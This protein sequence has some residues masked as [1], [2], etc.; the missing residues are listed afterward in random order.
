MSE[1]QMVTT[2][3]KALTEPQYK[4]PRPILTRLGIGIG[5]AIIDAHIKINY[6][7]WQVRNAEDAPAG[8][9]IGFAGTFA[10]ALLTVGTIAIA[11]IFT[12]ATFASMILSAPAIIVGLLPAE[13]ILS[14]LILNL[15]LAI[16][17][18]IKGIASGIKRACLFIKDEVVK[19]I[20]DE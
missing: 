9:I 18:I 1:T 4:A 20:P 17:A 7:L 2:P 16:P 12:T 5:R 8:I 15:V 6:E 11:S 3:A 10:T 13:F 14:N 19:R